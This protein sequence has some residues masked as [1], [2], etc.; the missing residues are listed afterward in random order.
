MSKKLPST[1]ARQ[2]LGF[3]KS[4]GFYQDRQKGSHLTLKHPDGRIVTIPIH[5]SKDIGK[6]LV[7]RIL[8]DG[9]YSIADF[10]RLK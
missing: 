1:N 9:E 2:L 5:T 7:S 10:I 6:G 4:Q 8:K 3:F